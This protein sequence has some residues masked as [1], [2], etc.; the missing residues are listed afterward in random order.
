MKLLNF[1][2]RGRTRFGLK[3]DSGIFDAAE[4]AALLG[5]PQP[6][7]TIQAMGLPAQVLPQL[8]EKIASSGLPPVPP[9]EVTFAP[10][11]LGCGKIIC[12]GINY[13]LHAQES[14][15]QAPAQPVIFSKF[16][17]AL[18]GHGQDIAMPLF[19][20]EIDYEAEL[21]AVIGRQA[22]NVPETEALSYVFGY[23][24]GNDLS[25]RDLQFLSGQWLIGK[26]ADGFAPIGPWLVTADEIPDPQ[27]LDI[28]C[29]VNGEKRQSANT[30]D[31][32]FSVAQ[33]ISYLSDL[34]TLEPGDL[35]FTGTPH[36]VAMGYP[37][38]RQPWLK[39]GD[40]VECAVESI[41]ALR[42]KMV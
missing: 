39:A 35:I 32:I 14:G 26:T 41:G 20:S 12:V 29:T 42:N 24:V 16:P 27:R 7:R 34:M 11:V 5:L 22:K 17:N 1:V 36:G 31:M 13:R 2:S 10:C 30:G 8:A 37:K 23:T 28:S 33:I 15:M 6:W 4:C 25:I 38:G 40:T 18:A 3:L 19:G 9:Q 21:V